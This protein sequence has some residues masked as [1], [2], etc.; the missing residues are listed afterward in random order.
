MLKLRE[1]EDA[2]DLEDDGSS[3]SSGSTEICVSLVEASEVSDKPFAVGYARTK[4]FG[5]NHSRVVGPAPSARLHQRHIP[6][7]PEVSP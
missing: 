5:K 3:C 1:S 6:L 2:S 4:G 7:D